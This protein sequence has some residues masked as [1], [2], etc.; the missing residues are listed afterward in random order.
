MLA[1]WKVEGTAEREALRLSAKVDLVAGTLRDAV[2]LCLEAAKA[3]E[4]SKSA[5]QSVASRYATPS[6]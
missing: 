4:E 1:C 6:A 2:R 5:A 3:G